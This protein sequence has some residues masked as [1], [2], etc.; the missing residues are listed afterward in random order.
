MPYG[1][2]IRVLTPKL[3]PNSNLASLA[4][5]AAGWSPRC[6]S[7]VTAVSAPAGI[8]RDESALLE[9]ERPQEQFKTRVHTAPSTPTVGLTSVAAVSATYHAAGA[10]IRNSPTTITAARRVRR[11]AAACRARDRDAAS[12]IAK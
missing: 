7:T 1:G 9:R 8:F 12:A 3:N 11:S 4:A 6:N 5:L 10:I 2:A